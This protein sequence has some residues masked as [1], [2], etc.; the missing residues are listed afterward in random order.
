MSK[1]STTPKE[2]RDLRAKLDKLRNKK[3][4]AVETIA[5]RVNE[6]EEALEARKRKWAVHVG[7]MEEA[8]EKL[9]AKAMSEAAD[10]RLNHFRAMEYLKRS[11]TRPPCDS[12][13]K[14]EKANYEEDMRELAHLRNI[15][16]AEE[17]YQT[18]IRA[19]KENGSPAKKAPQKLLPLK[20]IRVAAP[21]LTDPPSKK[22][23]LIR[24][25]PKIRDDAY[26]QAARCIAKYVQDWRSMD[27]D[28]GKE[29]ELV[30]LTE[31]RGERDEYIGD[32]SFVHEE[33]LKGSLMPDHLLTPTWNAP[34]PPEALVPDGDLSG[35]VVTTMTKNILKQQ[36]VQLRIS[37]LHSLALA[38]C[39]HSLNDLKATVL[40]ECNKQYE[41]AK[42]VKQANQTVLLASDPDL[43]KIP[44]RSLEVMTTFFKNPAHVEKLTLYILNFHPFVNKTYAS[45]LISALIHPDMQEA[46]NWSYGIPKPK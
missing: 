17:N 40:G 39:I 30:D 6:A 36:A 3:T 4:R 23:R 7:D 10:A 29:H 5:G 9:K 19:C 15:R 13:T 28:N 11:E 2:A 41:A 24:P 25:P 20:R 45:T 33:Q 27:G 14:Q 37:H 34:T 42:A 31:E 44:F 18:Y 32:P 16:Q 22:T 43:K 1:G 21:K 8:Q 35:D 12:D 46:V 26:E 38:R